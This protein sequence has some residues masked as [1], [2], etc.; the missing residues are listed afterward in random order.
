MHE[1]EELCNEIGIIDE[2]ELIAKDTTSNIKSLIDKRQIMILLENKK[3]D[4]EPISQLNL[5]YKL[6][7]NFL[8]IV[9]RPNEIKFNE[10]FDALK[11]SGIQIKDL[12]TSETK[13]EDVFL[14]LIRN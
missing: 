8:E 6:N 11:S 4:L 2:G 13:L 5:E 9:Y 10:I 3:F 7:D 14:K 1:A 12:T